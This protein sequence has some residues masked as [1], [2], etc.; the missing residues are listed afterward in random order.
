MPS[1]TPSPYP[2]TRTPVPGAIA[3]VS[4]QADPP[5]PDDAPVPEDADRSRDQARGGPREGG[6][7]H[8]GAAFDRVVAAAHRKA[9]S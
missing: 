1:G 2:V 3:P 6:L 5:V 8:A 9:A 4:P 7:R